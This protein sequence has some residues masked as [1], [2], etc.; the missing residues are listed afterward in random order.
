VHWD[1]DCVGE[2]VTCRKP[3]AE[4]LRSAARE[5][6]VE[7]SQSCLDGDAAFD[8]EVARL[9]GCRDRYLVLTG[10][11]RRGMARCWLC[12]ERDSHVAFDLRAAA[13]AVRQ[14]EQSAVRQPVTALLRGMAAK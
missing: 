13:D 4:L 2:R 5:L 14:Q 1:A 6:G 12:G 8:V 9:A 10:R 7:L 11:G 3:G